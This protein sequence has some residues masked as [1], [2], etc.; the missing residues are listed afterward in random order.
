M[1][2]SSVGQRRPLQSISDGIGA[3]EKTYS[4]L[5][6][7]W[8]RDSEVHIRIMGCDWQSFYIPMIWLKSGGHGAWH[9]VEEIIGILVNEHGALAAEDGSVLEMSKEAVAGDYV[10]KLADSQRPEAIKC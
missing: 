8:K 9:Y 3:H 5:A 2:Q 6:S 4:I 1:H 10:F 7:R